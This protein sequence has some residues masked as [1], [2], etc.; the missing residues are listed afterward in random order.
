MKS[1]DRALIK[2]FTGTGSKVSVQ[3][4][5]I[6][7][8]KHGDDLIDTL[9]SI[10]NKE[11]D[12]YTG[13]KSLDKLTEVFNYMNVILANAEEL[14]RRYLIKRLNKLATKLERIESERK[15]VFKNPDKVHE[16]FIKLLDR[17]EEL[18]ESATKEDSK[19]FDFMSYLITESQN[20]AYV[21]FT[22]KRLPHLVNIKDK[23]GKS[24]YATAITECLETL[25]EDEEKT[26][27]LINLISLLQSQHIF[28]ISENEKR[29]ILT[30]IY[31]CLEHM[32]YN[33]KAAKQN[34]EKIKYVEIIKEMVKQ[35]NEDNK[36]IESIA[37]KYN[38]P[39]YFNEDITG[40]VTLIQKPEDRTL[41]P[42]REIITDYTVTIDGSNAIEIDDALS[43]QRLPNGNY[44]L[45]VHIASVLGYFPYD[46]EIIEEAFRRNQS[47]Y[48]KHPYQDGD[49]DFSKV[50][51]IFPY[52]FSADKA[53]LK[54]GEPRL[55][56][57]YVFEIDP[58][59]NVVTQMFSK[60]IVTSD[61][62]I[63]Y[64]D[65]NHILRKQDSDNQE[66]Q[67]TLL[68]LQAVAE[69]LDKKYKASDIYEIMKTSTYNHSDLKV[70]KKGAENIIYQCMLLTGTR[71]G[72]FFK[73]NNY[74]CLFR[75]LSLDQE[76]D[77]RTSE[78]ID[79]LLE[80]NEGSNLEKISHLV[81][82]IYPKGRYDT[83]GRHDGLDLDYYCHCTSSLRRAQDILIEHALEVCYDQEPTE[84]ELAELREEIEKRKVQINSRN[85]P[86]D[87][88]AHEYNRTYQKRRH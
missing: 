64:Q 85:K 7:A 42:D 59:G 9:F 52:E 67:T 46:S 14:N 19:Q 27:Y 47:I 78:M 81:D 36:D 75:V 15:N 73:K 66:L 53:S 83:E 17:I 50:V 1:I 5:S 40:A 70:K 4:I 55:A 72:E 74:P 54:E 65:A 71:V 10:L 44:M 21:E 84:E 87:W 12:S 82:S 58:K 41:Y 13:D 88:F 33:K 77:Q 39:I 48:L 24:L 32:A 60:S 28:K 61:K 16:E 25:G 6:Y 62:K 30:E 76:T 34:R 57:T 23:N 26:L 69:I 37:T 38:I 63:S 31:K 43:C 49:D 68:N 8:T 80:G 51:P 3:E 35:E 29:K 20:I 45:G 22:L 2:Y 18:R 79:L 86:I 11:L 56:R